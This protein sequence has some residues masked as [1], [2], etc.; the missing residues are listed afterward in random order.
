MIRGQAH[1]FTPNPGYI[2]YQ[3]S[4]L[5]LAD[6]RREVEQIALNQGQ[7]WTSAQSVLVGSIEREYHLALSRDCVEAMTLDLARQYEQEFGYRSRID[8][9]GI[10]DRDQPLTL[11]LGGLWVNYQQQGEFNPLHQHDGQYSFVI[12]LQIPYDRDQ[13]RRAA[14]GQ[15]KQCSAG[16]F[17]FVYT[18]SL[19]AVRS[20]EMRLD[21]SWRNTICL[22]PS[23]LHHVVY[24]Y[25][26][27][28]DLR[29]SVSGNLHLAL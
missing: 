4:D 2:L 5:E 22:F 18:D 7:G 17:H 20:H 9:L 12:W 1:S 19:G 27:T 15:G 10:I 8:R 28:Q 23:E 16:D 6:L 3:A 29:I 24:P 25:Y 11:A 13:E 26:S 14:P 21:P